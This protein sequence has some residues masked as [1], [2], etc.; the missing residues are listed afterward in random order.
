MHILSKPRMLS[1]SANITNGASE[2]SS[3]NKETSVL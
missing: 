3:A 2:R 1:E